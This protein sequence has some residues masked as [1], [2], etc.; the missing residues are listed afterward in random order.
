MISVNAQCESTTRCSVNHSN[1]T[2]FAHAFNLVVVAGTVIKCS[3]VL[4]TGI[5]VV[6]KVSFP[7]S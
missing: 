4:Q 3:I 5:C 6:D 1:V 7:P 2:L